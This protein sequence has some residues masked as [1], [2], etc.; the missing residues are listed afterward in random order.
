MH[1][2]AQDVEVADAEVGGLE[3]ALK[4]AADD[5]K[6]WAAAKGRVEPA[7]QPLIQ[8]PDLC[9]DVRGY[10]SRGFHVQSFGHVFQVL[11]FRTP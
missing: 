2:L 9:L 7:A 6:V 8:G 3:R 1:D 10:C 5:G 4:V 11:R